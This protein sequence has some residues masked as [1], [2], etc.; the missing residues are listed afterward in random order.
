MNTHTKGRKNENKVKDAYKNKYVN[1]YRSPNVRGGDNDIFN[2]WDLIIFDGFC[3]KLIQVKSNMSDIYKFKK[4]SDKWLR[5]YCLLPN[6]HEP[7]YIFIYELFAIL[8]KGKV[9][10]WVWNHSFMKWVEELDVKKFYN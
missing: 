9:R 2:L 3:A 5:R 7:N 8:P 4:N 6:S 10:K 1:A